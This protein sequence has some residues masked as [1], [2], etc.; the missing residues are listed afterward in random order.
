MS[1]APYVD[2]PRKRSKPKRV[3]LSQNVIKNLHWAVYNDVKKAVAEQV[4]EQLGALP[5]FEGLSAPVQVECILYASGEREQDLDN[6]SF[7]V[8]AT[9][10]AVVHLGYLRDDNVKYVK[11]VVYS[12]GGVDKAN[13]RYTIQVTSLAL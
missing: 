5:Q 10:D 4:R 3:Y 6:C 7:V 13:P 8:K 9:M 11:R 2:L 1:I 12:Y